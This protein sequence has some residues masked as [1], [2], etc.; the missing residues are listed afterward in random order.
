[1]DKSEH[2]VYG[3]GEIETARHALFCVA[4]TSLSSLRTFLPLSLC[5]AC[6]KSTLTRSGML[7]VRQLL[8]PPLPLPPRPPL[9]QSHPTK[10]LLPR[11]PPH[12]TSLTPILELL[13]RP[14]P[15]R[16]LSPLPLPLPSTMV[17]TPSGVVAPQ[18]QAEAEAEAEMTG[19]ILAPPPHPLP[20]PPLPLPPLLHRLLPG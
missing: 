10:P 1:M 7:T 4:N 16:P 5:R 11:L 19:Q 2:G 15:H 20:L 18:L 13:L 8:L 14:Q 3:L 9:P 17:G 6:R 12:R